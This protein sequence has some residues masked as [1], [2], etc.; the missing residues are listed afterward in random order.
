MRKLSHPTLQTVLLLLLM[1]LMLP[2]VSYSAEEVTPVETDKKIAATVEEK[3][4]LINLYSWATILPK[5]LIDLQNEISNNKRII[6]VQK[7]L[8]ALENDIETI[9]WDTTMA[10]TSPDLQLLQITSLQNKTQKIVAR[11]KKNTDY[12]NETISFW[13]ATRKEWLRKKEQILL[14][15]ENKETPLILGAEQHKKLLS[16][17]DEAISLIES[18]LKLSLTVGKVIGELQISLY[19]IDG[20]LEALDEELKSTSV[21]Q[22]APSM[23]SAEFYSRL[24]RNII[25]QSYNRTK[26]FF[27]GR[28]K[29]VKDNLHYLIVG[30]TVF[31]ILCFVISKSKHLIGP[32]S[33]WMPF[34]KRPIATTVFMAST[35]NAIV[36][37]LPLKAELPEQ[38]DALL[39][40]ITLIAITRINTFL[41]E[42]IDRR[43]LLNKLALFM[44]GAVVIL[45]LGLPQIL[46]LLYVF[47]VSVVTFCYYLFQLPFTRGKNLKE[48]WRKRAWGVLPAFVI[49]SVVTGYDHLAIMT[50]SILLSSVIGCLVIW[51]LYR[52][53]L[54]FIDMI[55]S[56]L[57]SNLVK[58]N[59]VEIL[60]SVRPIIKWLHIFILIT[61]QSVIWDI[62]PNISTAFLSINNLGF[63][64][65]ELHISLRFIF[66]VAFVFYG[67]LITSRAV[68][69]LLLKN[70]LP[71]YKAEKGVQASV[72]RLAHYAIL[73]CGFLIM[74]RVLGFQL[75]QLTLLGGALGVGIGFGL[76]AIVN[77]FASGLILLFERPIKV[78]DTI[79]I[80]EQW[81]EVKGLGLR[82]T[83]IQTF[84]N[85]EIVV[86]NSDLI[87]GQVTNWTLGDRRVRVKV[88]VGVAYGTDVNRVIEILTSCAHANP[89]VLGTPKPSALFLAFGA[90]SLDFELRVWIPEFL[91]KLQVLSDLNQDID[92]EFSLNNIEIPFPQSDLHLRTVDESAAAKLSGTSREEKLQN[93]ILTT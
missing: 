73:T 63:D 41:M 52:F 76:Q 57:P 17:I 25:V 70:I 51:V 68:Q 91:D 36:T 16:T 13:S 39:Q 92:S 79:Q 6:A 19:T 9:R 78:G 83:I 24:N 8:P 86:P 10:Q 53:N 35:I 14:M 77:N 93:N 42:D 40:V 60:Q 18:H 2:L 30:C 67:A 82:A 85:A 48:V 49:I 88:P 84:D 33:E 37:V 22:T 66:T 89:M 71:R 64:I 23:L 21:Q 4:T 90:S 26:L 43:K 45:L 12:I 69:T 47:Y 34:S 62:Y 80:G 58:E 3:T 38:W 1:V 74:L 56:L 46:L 50:F 65:G 75:N 27:E 11:L 7:E 61:I 72:T 29:S 31:L 15:D 55:L 54:G 87:T 32:N 5:E 81:G 28:L 44:G 20:N 59:Y